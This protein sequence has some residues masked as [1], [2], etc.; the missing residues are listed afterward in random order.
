MTSVLIKK[1]GGTFG[2]KDRQAL[3]EDTGKTP[4]VS[5]GMPE[6]T[7]SGREALRGTDRAGSLLLA[8]RTAGTGFCRQSHPVHG[9][10]LRLP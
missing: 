5:Q 10:K 1:K 7:A 9:T 2:L 6:A 8:P 3:R 4:S